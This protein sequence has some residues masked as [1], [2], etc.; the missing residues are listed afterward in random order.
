MT[1][2]QP[3]F[4]GGFFFRFVHRYAEVFN[5]LV[6]NSVEKGHCIFV[7]DSPRDASTLCTG[8]GAGTFRVQPLA[9][10]LV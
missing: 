1:K 5:M 2:N 6:E 7:S 4:S 9:M 8:A 3:P 10:S